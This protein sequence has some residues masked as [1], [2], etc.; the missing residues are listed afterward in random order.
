MIWDHNIE[1]LE[2]GSINGGMLIAGWFV[3]EHAIKIDDNQGY[4]YFRK[5]PYGTIW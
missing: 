1:E 5:P 2:G 4:P 3:R